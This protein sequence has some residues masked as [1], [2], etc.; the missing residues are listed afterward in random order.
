MEHSI[1]TL[2]KTYSTNLNNEIAHQED[3]NIRVVE[4][5]GKFSGQEMAIIL[6]SKKRPVRD[7]TD[8]GFSD[9]AIRLMAISKT[10]A[11]FNTSFQDESNMQKMIIEEIQKNFLGLSALEIEDF[12]KI[13]MRGEY[14][15]DINNFSPLNLSRWGK[16]YIEIKRPVIGRYLIEEQKAEKEIDDRQ[17][18]TQEESDQKMK[19]YTLR[20]LEKLKTNPD[21][22]FVDYGNAIFNFL[23]E[24]GIQFNKETKKTHWKEAIGYY[25][26]NGLSI[27][28]QFTRE[29]KDFLD[30][31]DI[32][33]KKEIKMPNYFHS[34]SISRSKQNC[35]MDYFKEVI[36]M[37]FYL[38]GL[39]ESL[40]EEKVFENNSTDNQVLEKNL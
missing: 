9:L 26:L 39:I 21:Y 18:V 37:D 28:P 34:L 13:G 19:D 22:K 38:Q 20:E 31:S 17:K 7:L 8:Q 6:N 12:V 25:R 16:A 14:G 10:Y 24:L 35:L 2:S 23:S 27:F 33:K 3:A 32:E 29:H 30:W 11:G 5:S 15:G 4:Q 36:E 1:K 40:L